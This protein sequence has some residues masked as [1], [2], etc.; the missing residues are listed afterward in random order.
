MKYRK[1]YYTWDGRLLYRSIFG[2]GYSY[3]VDAEIT[4]W[5]QCHLGGNIKRKVHATWK[6]VFRCVR[7]A[8]G[9]TGGM[10]CDE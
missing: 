9:G 3:M 7:Q 1:K 10:G 5:R 8:I 4:H 6:R 2:Q